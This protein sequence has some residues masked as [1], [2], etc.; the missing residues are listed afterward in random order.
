VDLPA[1][2]ATTAATGASAGTAGTRIDVNRAS[3]EE[4]ERLPG[5]GPVLARRIV[6][7][8]EREGR[9]QSV[10][11]LEAVSGIGP[12]LRSRIEPFVEVIP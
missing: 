2:S 7:H 11:S 3:P 5:I 12:A 4:L 8:R 6:E 1:G 9:F 10:A